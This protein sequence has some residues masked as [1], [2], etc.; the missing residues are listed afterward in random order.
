MVWWL[1]RVKFDVIDVT[2]YYIHTFSEKTKSLWSHLTH[3]KKTLLNVHTVDP[4][5]EKIL[6]IET[7]W[8]KLKANVDQRL[9]PVV[10]YCDQLKVPASVYSCPSLLDSDT[11]DLLQLVVSPSVRVFGHLW[12]AYYTW[13]IHWQGESQII[14]L[15]STLYTL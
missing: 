7:V 3:T 15:T 5:S 11:N 1:T 13:Q 9:R 6:G 2:C 10:T 14:T 8:G 4:S 12:A